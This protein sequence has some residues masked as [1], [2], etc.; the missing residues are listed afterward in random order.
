[1]DIEYTIGDATAPVGTGARIIVHVCNDV[2]AWGRGFVVALSKRWPEPELRYRAWH[3]GEDTLPFALGE[4]QFVKVTDT[5]WI[6]NLIGQHDIHTHQGVPPIRYEA[7][8]AGLRKVAMEARRLGASVHMPRIGCGL[9]GGNWE[10]VS[11][12]I[13]EQLVNGGVPV[14]V[15]ELLQ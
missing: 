13:T 12:I 9:A 6:A 11:Q 3:K 7:L 10:T 15:Y 1:M 4:V 2:G 5:I 14:T 8:R